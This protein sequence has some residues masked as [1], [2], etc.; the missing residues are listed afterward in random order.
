MG[1]RTVQL[2]QRYLAPWSSCDQGR[3]LKDHTFRT[4]TVQDQYST[5]KTITWILFS[6]G[7]EVKR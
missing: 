6:Y 7:C 4:S 1:A 2:V 5:L 3:F